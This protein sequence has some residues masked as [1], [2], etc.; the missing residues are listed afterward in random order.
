M[1]WCNKTG[2]RRSHL[3]RG[4]HTVLRPNY[5]LLSSNHLTKTSSL[6]VVT[7]KEYSTKGLSSHKNHHYHKRDLIK[8][9]KPLLIERNRFKIMERSLPRLLVNCKAGSDRV[10]TT[11][12][13]SLL[14]AGSCQFSKHQRSH[15]LGNHDLDPSPTRVMHSSKGLKIYVLISKSKENLCRAFTRNLR[16]RI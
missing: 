5:K 16:L 6:A 2:L 4:W 3:S 12:R 15:Q 1:S 14:Q 10:S 8:L 13:R 11:Q 7:T 9:S